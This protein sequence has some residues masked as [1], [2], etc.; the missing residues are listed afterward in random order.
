VI[1]ENTL[2]EQC[3]RK[4]YG[5]FI[6]AARRAS[7]RAAG[8]EL[9]ASRVYVSKRI[10]MLEETPKIRLFHRTTRRVSLTERGEL[11]RGCI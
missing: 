3:R 5:V 8:D 6:N 11:M 2:R 10:S 7:F 1:L 9:G 4:S